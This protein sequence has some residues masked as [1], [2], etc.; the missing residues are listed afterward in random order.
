MKKIEKIQ[1]V[2]INIAE[3]LL[4]YARLKKLFL[5][6]KINYVQANMAVEELVITKEAKDL[7]YAIFNPD[8]PENDPGHL[9]MKNYHDIISI[10]NKESNEPSTSK[11]EN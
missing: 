2:I 3:I 6:F 4:V 7:S 11:N 1:N 10:Y 9:L 8:V 5:A